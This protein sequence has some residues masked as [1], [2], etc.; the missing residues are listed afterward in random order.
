MDY[1]KT[2]ALLNGLSVKGILVRAMDMGIGK[3]PNGVHIG[4][5]YRTLP[6]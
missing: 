5:K 1:S 6:L 3:S 2:S 4:V